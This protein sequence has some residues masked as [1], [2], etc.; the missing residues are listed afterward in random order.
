MR[1]GVN[2]L[3]LIPGEVGGS[4]TYLVET[5]GALVRDPGDVE[6]VLFTNSENDAFLRERF[7]R[8][9]QVSFE[10][11]KFR[12]QNRCVRIVREQVELPWRAAKAKVDVLWSPGYTCPFRV[13]CP[14]AVSILDM[15]YKRHP[16]DLTWTYRKATDFLLRAAVRAEAILAISE[17]SR[18]EILHFLGVPGGQVHV[19][20]LGVDPVFGK[21]GGRLPTGI[22]GSYL[23][24]V[25]NTYPHKN[26][27]TLIR[28]FDR[29]SGDIGLKLVIVGKPRLGEPEVQRALA[30]SGSRERVIRIDRLSREELVALYQ[31]CAAFVFPSLYEGFG[32]P[33]LEAMM[34]GVPV[35]A[36]RH[37]SMPEIGGGFVVWADVTDAAVLGAAIQGVVGWSAERRAGWTA[38]AREQAGGYTWRRTADATVAVWRAA[39]GGLGE[40]RAAFRLAKPGCLT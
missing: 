40:S 38:A 31:G 13:S 36:G 34:A 18:S 39:S 27:H 28:A 12:A 22:A 24:C 23:L 26:V 7:G 15:Q 30:E 5:L 29:I 17:F 9:P 33:V 3:F 11:L 8:S 32:L 37:G 16:G 35:L 6:L 19:T 20:P 2:S 1:V 10:L 4:E 14:Q 21:T 25:A